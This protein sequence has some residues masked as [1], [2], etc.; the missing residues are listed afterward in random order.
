MSNISTAKADIIA[1]ISGVLPTHYQLINP[2]QPEL[3][4]DLTFEKAW[5]LAYAEGENTEL[6]LACRMSVRRSL[7]L[8]LT[9]KMFSGQL[10]RSVDAVAVRSDA[11]DALFEDQYA[12]LKELETNPTITDSQ[13]ITSLVWNNDTGL[14]FVR[15]ERTDLLILTTTLVLNYFEEL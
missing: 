14:Q 2:Y 3:N 6:Q 9:R 12:V 5:G 11:E 15:T 4:D 13:V 8:V 1:V 10:M 7:N